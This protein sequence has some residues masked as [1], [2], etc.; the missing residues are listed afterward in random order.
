M[1]TYAVIGGQWGDEGKGKIVDYLSE[2]STYVVRFSGGNNAGHTVRIDQGEFRFHL[3]P[4]GIFWPQVT[5]VIGNGVVVDP[6][7][8]LDEID[9]FEAK[10]IDVSRLVIS[11]RAHLV[12]PYHVVLDSL[13]EGARGTEALGTTGKGIGPAYVDKASRTGIRMGDLI[14][15]ASLLTRLQPVMEQKNAIITK[16]YGGQPIAIEEVFQQLLTYA[17]RLS[18]F[19]GQTEVVLREALR[20]GDSVLLEGAQGTLL[21]ID[22]GT[23]P[24]VTSSSPS[25]GG[26]ITGLGLNPWSLKGIAGV[27]KAY[28]T[29]VGAGPLPTEMDEYM[30]D[31]IRKKA[32]E[33]GTTT[34]RPRRC[35]WFDGIAASYSTTVNGFTSAI[36]TRLDVLDGL[37]TVKVCVGYSLDGELTREFPTNAHTLAKCT[38]VYEELPGWERPTAG[39]T[40]YSELP[41]QASRYVKALE[42]L[43]NCPI[44][45]ISTG[46]RRDETIVVRSIL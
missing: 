38:P 37:E 36:L 34:G 24:F 19:I 3:I 8:L 4:A 9:E 27:F 15:P 35:G 28:S 13:E 10:G 20:R 32:W 1:P 40:Q 6:K 30:A 11:D 43:I 17:Q 29:R 33:F 2:R 14:D 42:E 12:M 7:A 22:H 31:I 26:A 46:P 23:Y 21:D 25:I 16:V 41:A 5:C 44:D 39:A 45:M 18:P